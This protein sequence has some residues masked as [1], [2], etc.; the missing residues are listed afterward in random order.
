MCLLA[1]PLFAL[2]TTFDSG[3]VQA[4]YTF[5]G[6]SGNANQTI[7][8]TTPNVNS[9]TQITRNSRTWNVTSFQTWPICDG[10]VT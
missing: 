8:P 9:F 7:S 1:A 6:W 4:G 5:A 10:G 3:P 2:T